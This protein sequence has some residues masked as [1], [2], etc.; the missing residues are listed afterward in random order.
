[1]T[2]Y[3]RGSDGF[4]ASTAA[5]IA[6]GWSDPVPGVGIEP[7]RAHFVL[8][9]KPRFLGPPCNPGRSDFPIPVLALAFP[10]RPFRDR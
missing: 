8:R 4:V 5:L 10:E 2:L 1:M 6:S 7:R 9:D 3:T